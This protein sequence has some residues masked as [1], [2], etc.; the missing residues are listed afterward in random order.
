[1]VVPH[2][3]IM[4]F[5]ASRGMGAYLPIGAYLVL[6][7]ESLL[8]SLPGWF[9]FWLML[10]RICK[11][12]LPLSTKKLI[13]WG[14]LQLLMLVLFAIIIHGLGDRATTWSSCADFILIGSV[15]IPA[16]VFLYKLHPIKDI[17]HRFDL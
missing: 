8:V 15:S 16:C 17:T 12:G 4:Y 5:F 11:T 1:M 6:V 14:T 2:V 9:V 7:L 3:Y 10:D 13:S